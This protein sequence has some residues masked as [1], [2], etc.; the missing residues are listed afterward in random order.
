MK[1]LV[2]SVYMVCIIAVCVLI[3]AVFGDGMQREGD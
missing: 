2:K 3:V 1:E